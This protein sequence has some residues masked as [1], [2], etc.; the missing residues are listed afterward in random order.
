MKKKSLLSLFSI[1]T[2]ATGAI[3]FASCGE[4]NSAETE[5]KTAAQ[6]PSEAPEADANN[7]VA[8]AG[9][10][11]GVPEA[12]VKKD[13]FGSLSDELLVQ[14]INM[15]ETMMS[16]KDKASAEEAVK[17]LENIFIEMES[18]K[19]RMVKLDPPSQEDMKR[20]DE[21]LNQ[22][23][24]EETCNSLLE[25]MNNQEIANILGPAMWKFEARMKGL[26]SLTEH[27]EGGKKA[28][29]PAPEAEASAAE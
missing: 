23:I 22:A 17:K 21:K 28:P 24:N 14:V 25:N 2:I 3:L 4:K 1:S 27:A 26:G 12:E 19:A 6:A 11:T 10:G 29:A 9:A 5:A 16:A 15:V 20:L 13:T 18:V 8:E 7:E